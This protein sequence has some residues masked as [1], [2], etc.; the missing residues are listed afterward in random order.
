MEPSTKS[1]TRGTPVLRTS[2]VLY[3]LAVLA[4]TATHLLW[5]GEADIRVLRLGPSSELAQQ[6]HSFIKMS[7]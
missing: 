5:K 4:S 1:D 7:T 2:D 3:R 6:G